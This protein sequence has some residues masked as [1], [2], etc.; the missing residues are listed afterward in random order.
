MSLPKM[1]AIEVR[2]AFEDE[3]D[4]VIKFVKEETAK[5]PEYS[6]DFFVRPAI[7][8]LAAIK[9]EKCYIMKNGEEIVGLGCILPFDVFESG[10]FELGSL[11]VK[12]EYQGQILELLA[13]IGMAAALVQENP[14]TKIYAIAGRT[15]LSRPKIEEL[16]FKGVSEKDMRVRKCINDFCV[17]K[18][19]NK[20][21]KK[22]PAEHLCCVI[23][24]EIT[25]VALCDRIEK[26]LSSK[27]KVDKTLRDG[28]TMRI[29]HKTPLYGGR[30][31]ETLQS[32][33]LKN[34]SNLAPRQA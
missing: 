15:S 1:H 9:K 18:P 2:E 25:A 23:Y 14:S 6:K 10:A 17:H 26:F 8:Y 19:P 30:Y 12:P 7:V 4:A 29:E 34:C 27:R 11:F 16:G 24:Y 33:R 28:S 31:K 22:K 20:T 32:W 3:F 21:C 13:P 5:L